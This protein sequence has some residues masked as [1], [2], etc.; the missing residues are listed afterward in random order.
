MSAPE[1]EWWH[2]NVLSF[3]HDDGPTNT[4]VESF[5][6]EHV[7][8]FM[9]PI[10]FLRDLILQEYFYVENS[11]PIEAYPLSPLSPSIDMIPTKTPLRYHAELDS[12]YTH[13]RNPD[14]YEA[15][16]LREVTLKS[17]W[18]LYQG[19]LDWCLLRRLVCQSKSMHNMDFSASDHRLL[20]V[21]ASFD[22]AEGT[23][24]KPIVDGIRQRRLKQHIQR[25]SARSMSSRSWILVCASAAALGVLGYQRWWRR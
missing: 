17:Y 8:P 4:I 5:F 21:E 24:T 7:L 1:A 19:K 20:M 23:T 10:P 9:K 13:L 6:Y 15:F 25:A 16:G 14:F 11:S 18:G 3:T 12:I 2:E 22:S